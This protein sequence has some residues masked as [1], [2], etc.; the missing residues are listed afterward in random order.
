MSKGL[1]ICFQENATLKLSKFFALLSERM[2]P[3][4][5]IVSCP[6]IYQEDRLASYI[7]N[8][9]PLIQPEGPSF[10][11]GVVEK[12]VKNI[13]EPLFPSPDGTYALFRANHKYVEILSDFTAS[14][15][16]WFYHHD[17]FLIASTS[18]RMIVSFLGNFYPNTKADSWMLSSGTLG[19]GEAWDKRLNHLRGNSR[20]ILERDTWKLSVEKGPS[21]KFQ[22]AQRTRAQHKQALKDAVKVSVESLD[23]NN[24]GWTLALSGGMDSRSILYHLKESPGLSTVTWGLSSSVEKPDSDASLAKQLAK[25]SGLPHEYAQT[26]FHNN[27]LSEILNRF[28]TAGEG[29]LDHL[30]GYMDGLKLWGQLSAAKRGIIRGYD[31]FGRKP[32]ITNDYQARRASGLIL[33]EDYSSSIIPQTYH[34]SP[35]DL[36]QHLLRQPEESLVHWRDRL[37]LESR[38]PFVTAA[39]EDIKTAYVEIANPLLC[40]KV[41]EVALSLPENLRTNKALF[42]EIVSEMFPGIPFA[43]R[44]SVQMVGDILNSENSKA[45]L[46]TTLVKAKG[47]GIFPD[48][49]LDDL[50]AKLDQGTTKNSFFR[51]LK[52]FI[53][54]SL[55]MPVE[56]Y[57][58]TKIQEEPMNIRRLALRVIMVIRM[59]EILA[60]DAKAGRIALGHDDEIQLTKS[61]GD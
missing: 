34:L 10:V 43:G 56:N 38:T 15:T 57:L 54:A 26:D 45:F 51:W 1:L 44:D 32:P 28:L 5:A 7:Y 33:T 39:L 25:L 9:A 13:F 18:Q 2:P 29:R 17:K 27:N 23:I 47:K 48:N 20:I 24:S 22:P 49:F 16:I 60:A 8:P 42:E 3:D 36:P 40:R 4:N 30:S 19:P 6:Y 14:R 11:L 35:Q 46:E 50:I 41:V 55:P 37:W 58:R 61:R 53:K 12:S 31:A 21:L 59:H 52:V